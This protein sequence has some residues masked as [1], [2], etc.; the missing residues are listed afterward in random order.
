MIFYSK[1]NSPRSRGLTSSPDNSCC[2]YSCILAI[3]SE[4]T[5]ISETEHEISEIR[6]V[7]HSLNFSMPRSCCSILNLAS[8]TLRLIKLLISPNFVCIPSVNNSFHCSSFYNRLSKSFWLVI[9]I[10]G[11]SI[12]YG[13]SLF[14]PFFNYRCSA[15]TFSKCWTSCICSA[16]SFYIVSTTA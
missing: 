5:S 10:T 4:T 15:R 7:A 8:S 2:T 6:V 11:R 9:V 12:T 1:S 16:F 3:E 14:E 13:K